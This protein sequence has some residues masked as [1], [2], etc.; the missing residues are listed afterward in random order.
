[1]RKRMLEASGER[2]IDVRDS[3]LL[4]VA[5]DTMLRRS[6]LVSLQVSDLFEAT[7]G[8][9]TFLVRGGPTGG[10]GSGGVAWIAPETVRMVRAW[11][12]GAAIA[13]GLVFR[14]IRRG[15]IIGERRHPSQVPRIPRIREPGGER[16]RMQGAGLARFTT[17]GPFR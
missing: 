6:E 13:E 7:G 17:R 8:D 4:V 2:L 1:M 11:L 10:G 3:A 15:G 12:E 5:Y 16:E 9:A 14:S